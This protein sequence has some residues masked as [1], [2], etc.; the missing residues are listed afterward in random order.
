MWQVED[1]IHYAYVL[2]FYIT[3]GF[4]AFF[5]KRAKIY[6]ASNI[7]GRG[8]LF[9]LLSIL[10]NAAIFFIL[11]KITRGLNFT[12]YFSAFFIALGLILNFFLPIEK[13]FKSEINE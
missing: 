5:E 7:I 6:Y 13:L 8:N 12:F 10:S 4:T 2:G 1:L 9:L 11:Y 3:L